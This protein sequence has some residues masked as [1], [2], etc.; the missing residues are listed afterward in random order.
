MHELYKLLLK[1]IS[2]IWLY[3]RAVVSVTFIFCILG[4]TAIYF[5]PNQYQASSVIYIDN[6]SRLAQTL[7]GIV[8]D[9]SVTDTSLVKLAKRKL[10]TRSNIFRVARQND[11]LKF[12]SDD[13]EIES[14]LLEIESKIRIYSESQSRNESGLTIVIAYQDRDPVL[15]K[16][17]VD[18]LQEILIEELL[19]SN[20]ASKENTS[21]FL[22]NQIKTYRNQ[23]LEAEQHLRTFESE[24][25]ALIRQG[26][27]NYYSKLQSV[28][29]R[30]Q[31]T[32]LEIQRQ[33]NY[34]QSLEKQITS[35]Q[36]KWQKT[37]GSNAQSQN[38]PQSL[39]IMKQRLN[40]LR[41]THTDE[42][43]D[44]ISLSAQI[45]Q[46]SKNQTKE[47]TSILNTAITSDNPAIQKLGISLSETISNYETAKS[48]HKT[49]VM[50]KK[51]LQAQVSKVLSA[52]KELSR[53]TQNHRNFQQRYQD[54]LDR[55]QKNQ[56]ANA[57]DI[58]T[59]D[60][61]FQIIEPPV[62]PKIPISPN[63]ILLNTFVFIVGI[64]S[65]FITGLAAS[66]LKPRIHSIADLRAF[67]LPILGKITLHSSNS[68]R[69]SKRKIQLYFSLYVLLFIMYV[70]IIL[71]QL[72]FPQLYTDHTP[73]SP[74]LEN[75]EQSN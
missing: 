64:L 37:L 32:I 22:S 28:D 4:W 38:V 52:E 14:L 31:D 23:L 69:N 8:I 75:T 36:S 47:T 44:V 58:N 35:L 2:S 19:G 5:W 18:S 66:Q 61:N 49:L 51:E 11:L 26:G 59:S 9:N 25:L 17:I 46:M 16:N 33:G 65:G 57:V 48:S 12:A 43:P 34:I 68:F 70:C 50:Q 20:L 6:H 54:L 45:A 39:E 27:A 56:I 41:L 55:Q 63:R 53:L 7:K 67:D 73:Q 62:V 1:Y 40:E 3:R 60:I 15:T 29:N 24:N 30:I 21:Q 13:I 71:S 42:H 74:I 72:F 10:S